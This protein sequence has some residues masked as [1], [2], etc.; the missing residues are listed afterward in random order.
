MM[1]RMA[2]LHSPEHVGGTLSQRISGAPALQI[3]AAS[4]RP[5]QTVTSPGQGVPR[6]KTAIRCR[7]ARQNGRG[8]VVVAMATAH[9]VPLSGAGDL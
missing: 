3:F 4:S 1:M 8:G 7:P 5:A 2:V 6:A 9:Q